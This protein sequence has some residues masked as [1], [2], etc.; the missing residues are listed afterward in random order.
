MVRLNGC[1]NVGH[2]KLQRRGQVDHYGGVL[3]LS[4]PTREAI[5]LRELARTVTE[6]RVSVDHYGGVLRLFTLMREVIPLRELARTVTEGRGF[7]PTCLTTFVLR[8]GLNGT[9]STDVHRKA[10]ELVRTV[11]EGCGFDPTRLTTFRTT[12]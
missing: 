7:D 3:R 2:S 12:I 1:P 6:G 8:Y 9:V 4:T 5:P 10:Q 11:T